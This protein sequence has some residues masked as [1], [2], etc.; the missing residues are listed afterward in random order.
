MTDLAT[1]LE[2]MKAVVEEIKEDSVE[3]AEALSENITL[4][5]EGLIDGSVTPEDGKEILELHE[6]TIRNTAAIAAI[7]ITSETK[8]KVESVLKIAFS[9][10][11]ALA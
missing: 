9:I 4:T 11:A 3:L 8:D 2:E 10:A 7:K 1:K 5:A 6:Q